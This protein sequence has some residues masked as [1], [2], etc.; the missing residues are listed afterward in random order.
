MLPITTEKDTITSL[1]LL[2]QINFFRWKEGEKATTHADLLTIIETEFTDINRKRIKGGVSPGA[3][4]QIKRQ[5]E[6]NGIIISEYIHPQNK[7][8]YQYYI[9][10]LKQGRQVLM[11][12]SRLVR[13]AVIEYIDNLEEKIKRIQLYNQNEEL[14]HLQRKNELLTLENRILR[15]NMENGDNQFRVDF[16]PRVEEKPQLPTI[17]TKKGLIKGIIRHDPSYRYDN[18]SYEELYA[19]F[20]LKYKIDLAKG[21]KECKR[22]PVN[23]VQ[24]IEKVLK[25][26]DELVE[27]AKELYP[28]GFEKAKKAYNTDFSYLKK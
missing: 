13:K 15:A 26:I 11:K 5:L 7:Q 22:P 1:E 10:K 19:A 3:D 4:T 8:K 14:K 21:L 6:E 16:I 18:W 24:Y 28:V 23:K 17:A 20:E 25:K 2:E 9:L 12:E 27:I